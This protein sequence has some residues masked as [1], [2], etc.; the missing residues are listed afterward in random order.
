MGNPEDIPNSQ[1]L[2]LLQTVAAQNDEIKRDIDEIKRDINEIKSNN[3][4]LEQSVLDLNTKVVRVEAENKA[5]KLE[6]LE[7]NRK[8]RKNNIILFGVQQNT[9]KNIRKYV[10]TLIKETID[11][12]IE[13]SDINDIYYIGAK[14]DDKPR[15]IKLELKS[16]GK[17]QD[18]FN[19]IRK[20]KGT[21]ISV[22]NDLTPHDREIQSELYK[23]LK[24]ARGKSYL[25]KISKNT[26]IVNGQSYTLED[27]KEEEELIEKVTTVENSHSPPLMPNAE[28]SIKSNIYGDI[29][30]ILITKKQDVQLSTPKTPA[31]SSRGCQTRLKSNRADKANN[32]APVEK[33]KKVKV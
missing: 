11:I 5:L 24:I 15:P 30:D 21:G 27:L 31:A 4:K 28:V 33:P 3:T 29:K 19:N 10:Q 26:L 9:A 8:I 1:I 14:K 18:I 13:D 6:L 25:A 16:Y 32:S 17:K 22:S 23:H 7:V 2:E 12:N 20:F